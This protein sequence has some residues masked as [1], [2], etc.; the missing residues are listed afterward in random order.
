[1]TRAGPAAARGTGAP[2]ALPWDTSRAPVAVAL[3]TPDPSTALRWA[4]LLGGSAAAL[5]VGLE[6]VHRGGPDLVRRV[7]AHGPVFVD[8]KLHDIP[9][10]VAGAAAAVGAL[11]PAVVTVHAAA[12]PQAVAAAADGLRE[13]APDALLAAVTVLT[14]LDAADLERLGLRGPPDRAVLR[15]A[16]LAVDAGATALVCSPHEVA[17]VREAVGARTVLITPGVRPAGTGADDQRRTATPAQARSAGADLLV[18]GRPVTR[19]PEPRE[20]LRRLVEG[21]GRS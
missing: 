8:V 6:L 14:S 19:A 21:L 11:H 18:V 17:A 4:E 16:R 9:A 1:M 5:K 13:E 12:G 10:T 3:D 2:R 7:G 20:A 15:L